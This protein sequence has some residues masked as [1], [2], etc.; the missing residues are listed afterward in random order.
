MVI[1]QL[2]SDLQFNIWN[3]SYITSQHIYMFDTYL[4]ISWLH[5]SN[6]HEYLPKKVNQIDFEEDWCKHIHNK[7][8]QKLL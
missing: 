5:M 8:R 4:G 1:A 2:I 3:I 7:T 6:G